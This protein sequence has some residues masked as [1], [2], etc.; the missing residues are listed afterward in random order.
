MYFPICNNYDLN[1]IPYNYYPSRSQTSVFMTFRVSSLFTDT[2]RERSYRAIVD[3]LV[4]DNCLIEINVGESIFRNARSEWW[5]FHQP[6]ILYTDIMQRIKMLD[7]I[8]Y[9]ESD[10]GLKCCVCVC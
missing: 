6:C 5:C 9:K 1:T 10:Q 2:T 4:N 8:I 7:K 3:K